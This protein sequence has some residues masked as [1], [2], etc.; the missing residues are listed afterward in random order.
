MI[1]L[2][3]ISPPQTQVPYHEGVLVAEFNA[4]AAQ[5]PADLLKAVAVFAAG[6]A[7]ALANQNSEAAKQLLTQIKK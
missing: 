4:G 7:K 2:S 3:K 5:R 6:G 1:H